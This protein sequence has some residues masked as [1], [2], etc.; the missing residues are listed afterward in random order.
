MDTLP[1]DKQFIKD[2]N[3]ENGERSRA[4]YFTHYILQIDSNRNI[5]EK[6]DAKFHSFVASHHIR[7]NRQIASKVRSLL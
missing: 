7:I 3:G 5:S 6:S 2:E 1:R 4:L